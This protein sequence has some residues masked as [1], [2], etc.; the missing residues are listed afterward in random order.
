MLTE[1]KV[2]STNKNENENNN[3]MD[4][5]LI[6]SNVEAMN[7]SIQVEGQ[8]LPR[9]NEISLTDANINTIYCV[10]G[11]FVIISFI[12]YF[13]IIFCDFYYANTYSSCLDQTTYGMEISMYSY[14]IV[15]A[16]YNLLLLGIFYIVLAFIDVNNTTIHHNNNY[17]L[18]IL[19]KINV[20]FNIVWTCIGAIIFWV[21]LNKRECSNNVDNYLKIS[22]ITKL[23]IMFIQILLIT[24][25]KRT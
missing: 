6:A 13:P 10:K 11:C 1:I 21:Y 22:I 20:S 4:S 12:F 16:C 23:V 17:L 19:E 7:P 5:I 2:I 8:I 18:N 25:C 3:R 9:D 15:T 14:L 24:C